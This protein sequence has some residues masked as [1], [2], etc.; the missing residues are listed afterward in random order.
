MR[1]IK[2]D[3]DIVK[4]YAGELNELEQLIVKRLKEEFEEDLKRWNAYIDEPTITIA[5]KEPDVLFEKGEYAL[6]PQFKE[7]L[8]DFFPRYVDVLNS[9]DFKDNIKSIRIEGHTSSEWK[10]GFSN[11]S[12]REA[13]AP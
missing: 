2:Y 3:N 8:N 5:F 11:K 10:R 1:E 4:D 7:I 12:R 9:D 6:K 13:E